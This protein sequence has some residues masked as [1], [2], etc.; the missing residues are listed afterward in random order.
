MDSLPVSF[1]VGISLIFS[2]RF[3]GSLA[4][5]G[6]I[7]WENLCI[8]QSWIDQRITVLY[9]WSLF[10][11][12]LCKV[13]SSI[14]VLVLLPIYL[15]LEDI[16]VTT[17][18]STLVEIHGHSCK[19][20]V[21]TGVLSCCHPNF[22]HE[23]SFSEI[24]SVRSVIICSSFERFQYTD[25]WRAFYSRRIF[26]KAE[27]CFTEGKFAEEGTV[28]LYWASEVWMTTLICS[29]LGLNDK[30][31]GDRIYFMTAQAMSWCLGTHPYN[32]MHS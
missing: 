13:F 21:S 27:S 6:H 15:Y 1:H 25:W 19:I 32:I 3:W 2:Q 10:C 22:V 18:E 5:R 29:Q 9:V 11:I 4:F 24:L 31:N 20:H 7:L 28:S 12:S 30:K 23:I 26:E 16:W 17:R 8:V 14:E